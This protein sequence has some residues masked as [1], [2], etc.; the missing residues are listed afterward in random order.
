V[1]ALELGERVTLG[2][3]SAELVDESVHS[4]FVVPRSLGGNPVR[5]VPLVC[6]LHAAFSLPQASIPPFPVECTRLVCGRATSPQTLLPRAASRASRDEMTRSPL[7]ATRSRITSRG[8]LRCHQ[9]SARSTIHMMKPLLAQPCAARPS[10][11]ADTLKEPS[12]PSPL[13]SA[14]SHAGEGDRVAMRE[15]RF[16]NEL[17]VAHA[18]SNPPP[19]PADRFGQREASQGRKH[20]ASPKL[21]AGRPRMRQ[22]GRSRET[23]TTAVTRPLFTDT[24]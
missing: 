13:P 8:G 18:P 4:A 5:P 3:A 2:Q 11:S 21:W 16:F 10:G 24:C 20:A 23:R 22:R 14:A 19:C 1:L 7:V 9:G 12:P 6:R 17:L 15:S